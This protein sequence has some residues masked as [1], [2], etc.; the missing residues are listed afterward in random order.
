MAP[1]SG[2]GGMCASPAPPP[3]A[4]PAPAASAAPQ[5]SSGPASGPGGRP[6]ADSLARILTSQLEWGNADREPC[7][8]L[9]RQLL[10]PS[11][12]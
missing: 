8:H 6:C 2:A 5:G 7:A 4:P 11:S 9:M 12:L 10:L 3:G 1:V